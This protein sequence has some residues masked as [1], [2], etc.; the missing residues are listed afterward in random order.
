MDQLERNVFH[1][2]PVKGYLVM[3]QACAVSIP[4]ILAGSFQVQNKNKTIKWIK[5][6][7]WQNRTYEFHL[8]FII[9][10]RTIW[11]RSGQ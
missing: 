11:A 5:L 1:H 8:I 3:M 7:A 2:L 10:L 6:S 4:N 9:N